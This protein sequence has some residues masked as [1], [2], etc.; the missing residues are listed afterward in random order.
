MRK[1][2][3]PE[4]IRKVERPEGTIVFAYG[5]DG[6][7]YGVKKRLFVEVDG[8]V[9]QKDGPTVGHIVDGRYVPIDERPR[10]R[11]E[12]ADF[13][14]WADS[15]LAVNL[16]E[17][18]LA[19]LD[20]TYNSKDARIAYV[21]A[22]LRAVEPGLK[23]DELKSAYDDSYLHVLFPDVPL[24]RNSVSDFL[25]DLGRTCT[26]MTD[27]MRARASRVPANHTVAVDGMLK[28]DES[29]VNAFS[30]HS[31]KALKKGTRDVSLIYAF[32]VDAMEPICSKV[33]PGNMPDTSA[34]KDFLESYGIERGL[35]VGDKGFKYSSAK[36]V[37]ISH[38]DLHFL[39]PL[40]RDSK[41]IDEYRLLSFDSALKNR[42]AVQCR[43]VRMIDGRYLYS[44]RDVEVA[45][46]EE[47]GWTNTHGS[48]DPSE[49]EA[50]RREFGTIVF[51]S[52]LDAPPESIYT[53][54]E[55]RWE[56]EV[57]FRFYKNI[58]ELDEARVHSD[59]SLIGTEFVNLLSVIITCRLRKAF[60]SVKA[61][62]R[63]PYPKCM[64]YLR[65]GVMTRPTRDSEWAPRKITEADEK[66]FIELGIIEAPKVEK[67]RGRPRK[68]P[69]Q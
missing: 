32:D 15:Q 49:L 31:R 61:L 55:E 43:K 45:R 33:Y 21:M 59:Q 1:M 29:D 34:F 22:V 18:I 36:S 3:V 2:A 47:Q 52:D 46:A 69:A 10:I 67:K 16:S 40:R 50:L 20:K 30:D 60:T 14:Y 19:D 44:F 13:L 42:N 53:A 63:K 11:Y 12:E 39:L 4:D 8:R 6:D 41:V 23:D 51:I 64:R 28:S 35:I 48:Y 62:S 58:L 56:L 24:S 66:V 9:V 27:F 7:R 37:F 5:K 54:Y 38:P 65:R 26:H 25:Y 68:N 57:V 17:D